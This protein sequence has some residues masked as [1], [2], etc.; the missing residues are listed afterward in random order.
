[1]VEF[2]FM[3]KGAAFTQECVQVIKQVGLELRV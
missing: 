1:M 3:A 2:G